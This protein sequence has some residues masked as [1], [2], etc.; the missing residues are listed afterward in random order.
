MPFPRLLFSIALLTSTLNAQSPAPHSNAEASALI[1]RLEQLSTTRPLSVDESIALASALTAQGQLPAAKAALHSALAAHPDAVELY[2]NLALVERLGK[3]ISAA[4]ATVDKALALDPSNP[5]LRLLSL[6]LQLD[7]LSRDPTPL[8]RELL[9]ES[10]NDL[11]LLLANATLAT[12]HNHAAAAR[13]LLSKAITLHHDSAEVHHQLGSLLAA[14]QDFSAARNE[15]EA[16][17]H[18]G[19]ETPQLHYELARVLSALGDTTSAHAA[20]NTFAAEK[21]Q[22]ANAEHAAALMQQADAAMSSADFTAAAALYR[23]AIAADPTDANL[24]YKL[25]RAL[26]QLHNIPD[27]IT[28]LHQALDLNP[29]MVEP[30]N[31]LAMLELHASDFDSARS[32]LNA[33]IEASPTYLP[34]WIN[35]AVLEATEQHWSAARNAV[36]HALALDPTNAQAQQLRSAIEAAAAQ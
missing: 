29:K 34:A 28:A 10:P 24:P 5:S 35:L 26:D 16:A 8:A 25:S 2:R 31:Q 33:A 3:E 4:I 19:Q 22:Q 13:S 17:L 14:Q 20:I 27:E 18:L 32:H 21:H 6:H 30:L 36:T 1:H 11:D 12:R 23:N 7:D 15:L 9:T